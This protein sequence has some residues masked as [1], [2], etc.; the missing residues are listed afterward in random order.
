NRDGVILFGPHGLRG[1]V[2]ISA[3]GGEVTQVTKLDASRQEI[4]HGFPTFLP[5]GRHFLYS[6]Q[7]G[8]KET[9]GVY[10][11]SLDGTLKQ[12]LL[13]DATPV[14]YIAAVPGAT[15]GPGWLVFG[16]AGALLAQPF[17]TS[18]LDFTGEP[19]QISDK[20]RSD[21]DFIPNFSFSASDNG[22][23]VFDPS[24]DR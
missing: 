20:V 1:L 24:L 10:L 4:T 15:S 14:E 8:R 11:G 3:T 17:D 23:L 21:C 22:V 7:S 16:R 12:R 6:I 9:R 5:D 13:E 18:R 2:R 19:I